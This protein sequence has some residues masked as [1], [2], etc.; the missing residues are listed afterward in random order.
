MS[1]A[2]DIPGPQFRRHGGQCFQLIEDRSYY[3][4]A[5]DGPNGA[6]EKEAEA[7]KDEAMSKRASRHHQKKSTKL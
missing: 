4:A 1:E 7:L 5:G 6:E 3:K 2:R